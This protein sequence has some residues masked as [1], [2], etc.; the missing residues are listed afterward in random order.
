MRQL[1]PTRQ[2][3]QRLRL[4]FF[5]GGRSVCTA[6]KLG[7]DTEQDFSGDVARVLFESLVGLDN[8]SSDDR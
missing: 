5:Q 4:R 3:N 8:E 2:Q 6:F 7:E 1:L